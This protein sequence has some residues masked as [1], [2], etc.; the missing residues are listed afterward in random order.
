MDKN[1]CK[2][3]NDHKV[4]ESKARGF[5]S[6]K[7]GELEGSTVKVLSFKT[8]QQCN[9]NRAGETTLM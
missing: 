1:M 9:P 8:Q 4:S 5:T 2:G 3:K 7:L 6:T